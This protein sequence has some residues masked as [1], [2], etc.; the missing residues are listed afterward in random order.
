METLEW[1][2]GFVTEQIAAALGTII[3]RAILFSFIGLILGIAI[4]WFAARLKAF[5]RRYKVWTFFAKLNYVYIP[6]LF[7]VFGGFM[8]GIN[9]MHHRAGKCIDIASEPLIQYGCRLSNELSAYLPN[10]PAEIHSKLSLDSIISS[11]LSEQGGLKNGT[12][13]HE[14]A[15]IVSVATVNTILDKHHIPQEVRNPGALLLVLK[16]ETQLSQTLMVLPR[17]AHTACDR[18]FYAKYLVVWAFFMPFFMLP[19]GEYGIHLV[20]TWLWGILS[21]RPSQPT[22]PNDDFL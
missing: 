10:L 2:A 4:V 16:S 21:R 5:S 3:L 19:L 18:F 6:T 12:L 1:I 20:V 7:M 22:P 13:A 8:G 14:M 9:G 15:S 17:A 11:M